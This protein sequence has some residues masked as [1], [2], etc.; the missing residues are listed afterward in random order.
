MSAGRSEAPCPSRSSVIDA[1]AALGERAGERL[2]HALGEQQAVDEDAGARALA[3]L[4][5]G[6]PL[7]LVAEVRHR[8]AQDTPAPGRLSNFRRPGPFS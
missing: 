7:A 3:V 1:V 2:V 4:G 6:D 5:V 8:G